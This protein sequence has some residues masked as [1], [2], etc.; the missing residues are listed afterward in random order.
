MLPG[1]HMRSEPFHNLLI[2]L[3]LVEQETVIITGIN[4]ELV[5]LPHACNS[6]ARSAPD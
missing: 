2:L 3:L 6:C 4:D 1:L 5:D